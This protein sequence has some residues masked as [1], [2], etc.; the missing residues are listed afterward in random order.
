MTEMVTGEVYIFARVEHVDGS[1][2]PQDMN[3]TSIGRKGGLHGV[4]AE[5]LLDSSLLESAPEA[6]EEGVVVVAAALEV[7]A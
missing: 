1:R 3:V 4:E 5:Q 2:V 6:D 7:L